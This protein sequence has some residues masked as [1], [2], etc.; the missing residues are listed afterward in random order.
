MPSHE[1]T[2][3]SWP[4]S[5]CPTSG[6]TATNQSPAVFNAPVL[7]ALAH[8]GA[9]L[10]VGPEGVVGRVVPSVVAAVSLVAPLASKRGMLLVAAWFGDASVPFSRCCQFVGSSLIRGA[11]GSLIQACTFVRADSV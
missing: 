1:A 2:R 6:A 11:G 4:T 3:P 8:H 7:T 5:Q 10:A 9:S